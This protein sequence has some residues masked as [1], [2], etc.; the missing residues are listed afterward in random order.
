MNRKKVVLGM[1]GEVTLQFLY[2]YF[3]NKDMK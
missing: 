1:S 2:I 3:K